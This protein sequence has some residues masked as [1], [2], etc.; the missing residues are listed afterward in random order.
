MSIEQNWKQLDEEKDEDLSRL[1][2]APKLSNPSVR[3]PLEKV[4][5]RVR[6]G[7]KVLV[8]LL[9]PLIALMIGYRVW[10][11]ELGL[12]VM[13]AYI[14]WGIYQYYRLYSGINN[15]LLSPRPL[16]DELKQNYQML[17][18]HQKI[19]LR[20]GLVVWPISVVAGE[21]FGHML[22]SSEPLTVYMQRRSSIV[23]WI[24]GVLVLVPISY[25]VTKAL[26]K[27]MYEQELKDLEKNIGE[28]ESED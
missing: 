17:A 19:S 24:V 10:P 22:G 4:R 27:K 5:D 28:L 15:T 1:L 14:L 20:S 16:L 13:V 26:T 25:F 18:R 23:E 21:L 11:L 2:Q 9:C 12:G 3:H 7:M 6:L 8:V